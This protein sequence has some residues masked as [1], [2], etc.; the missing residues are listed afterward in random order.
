[1]TFGRG[2]DDS[3]VEDDPLEKCRLLCKFAEQYHNREL[4][5]EMEILNSALEDASTALQLPL[6]K[7]PLMCVEGKLSIVERFKLRSLIKTK[8]TKQQVQHFSEF[9]KNFPE[10]DPDPGYVSEEI[11]GVYEKIR[12]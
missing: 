8:K 5:V 3:E 1:M 2:V 9:I 6:D 4:K 12:E 7:V 11:M 10:C